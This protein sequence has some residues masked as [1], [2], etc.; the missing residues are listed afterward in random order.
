MG[1]VEIQRIVEFVRG[2]LPLARAFWLWGILGGS[3]VSLFSTLLALTLVTAGA[4]PWL[5]VLVFAAHIPLEPGAARRRLAQ[6]WVGRG[7][8]CDGEIFALG[9][10]RMGGCTQ[11]SLANRAFNPRTRRVAGHSRADGGH[12]R[13]QSSTTLNLRQAVRGVARIRS[14]CLDSYGH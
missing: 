3:I 4:T 7:K 5:A 9:H 8:S 1:R 12:R 10:P 13:S 11:R 14:V 2:G 6:S